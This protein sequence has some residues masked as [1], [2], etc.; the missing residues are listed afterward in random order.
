M[1]KIELEKNFVF[2]V[3]VKGE[4]VKDAYDTLTKAYDA[5][6]NGYVKGENHEY[7]VSLVS[8]EDVKSETPMFDVCFKNGKILETMVCVNTQV[9]E[10]DTTFVKVFEN[11]ECD[12]PI[13]EE[14]D[15]KS[16]F[17]K[18][19]LRS[20][21]KLIE[22]IKSFGEETG[23]G[24]EVELYE[25]LD[26]RFSVK[27]IRIEENYLVYDWKSFP[28]DWSEQRDKIADQYEDTKEW[29]AIEGLDS[30]SEVI[31]FWRSCLNRA[32]RYWKMSSEELDKL[33][34]EGEENYE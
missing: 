28:I 10:D 22:D 16:L 2:V 21:D 29:F 23:E 3:T 18:N 34:E 13:P 11:V 8:T 12:N 30:L 14:F 4:N 6:K 24:E 32:K 31:K 33:S 26:T 20:F 17:H 9:R 5:I 7:T 25:Y 19:T 15:F 1:K 27:N